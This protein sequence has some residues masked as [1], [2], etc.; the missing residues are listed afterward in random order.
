MP[1]LIEAARD[2]GALGAWLSGAGSTVA[3]FARTVE[4]AH[5]IAHAFINESERQGVGGVSKILAVDGFGATIE[6]G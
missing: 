3:A 6:R 4:Q 5:K 1:A 2:A